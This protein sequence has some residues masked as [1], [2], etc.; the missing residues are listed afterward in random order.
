MHCQQ[1][2]SSTPFAFKPRRDRYQIGHAPGE[3]VKVVTTRRVT[4][5]TEAQRGFKL[6]AFRH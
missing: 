6:L 2:A 5:A 4:L 1:F 3:T